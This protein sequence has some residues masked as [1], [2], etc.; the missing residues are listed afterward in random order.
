MR[1]AKPLCVDISIIYMFLFIAYRFTNI[2]FDE[3]QR[4]LN[5]WP[6][7][8]MIYALEVTAFMISSTC[9]L[10]G[11]VKFDV[12]AALK[13]MILLINVFRTI[14]QMRGRNERFQCHSKQLYP[15]RVQNISLKLDNRNKIENVLILSFRYQLYL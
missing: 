7:K 11:T 8:A 13:E 6:S 10:I 14:F 12:A 4:T 9:H 1:H 2:G 5:I 3:I 15:C